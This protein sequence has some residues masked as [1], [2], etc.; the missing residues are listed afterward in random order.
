[1]KD[2]F[3]NKILL[4]AVVLFTTNV[5]G[6]LP[7]LSIAKDHRHFSTANG[8]PFFWMGDTGWLLFVKT[9]REE[10]THYL[11]IRQQQGFNMIQVMVIHDVDHA[12]NKYGDTAISNSDVAQPITTPGNDFRDAKQY[13]FWDHAEF[14][15]QEAAKRNIYLALVPVWGSNIKGG[16]VSEKQAE[17]YAKFLAT[18][19]KKYSNI[20]WL[21]GGDIPGN[22][23]AEVWN[24]I[25]NTLKKYDPQHLVSFHP[26]GRTT[27]SRWFHDQ[28]WLDFNMFQS[29]HRNYAQD[30][31]AGETHY[32]EDNWRYVAEDLALK[33][34]KPTLDGEPSYEGIPQGLHDTTERYWYAADIRRYAYWNVLTGAAG[35]TYGNNAVMQFFQPA[36]HGMSAYGAKEFWTEALFDTAATQMQCVKKLMEL[37]LMTGYR[38]D[39]ALVVNNG[40]RYNYVAAGRGKDF[41]LFYTYNGR[42]FNVRMGK[43]PGAR[44]KANWYNPATGAIKATMTVANYGTRFFD[45]PGY[46]QDGNDWILI[47][48][49]KK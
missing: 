30:T 16:H 17:A 42:N 25:G 13:D 49:T 29:G 6:Q 46:C 33:P 21:N 7:A 18:R 48:E 2:R 39:T 14:I 43:L 19:F 32:G 1:M 22:E 31:S 20:V 15:V 3:L 23:H 37:H 34:A 9:T 44:V 27:S 38:P 26:R 12:V 40:T 28:H 47:L 11:D 10:A 8:K 5:Q 36:D 4:A 24:T 41:E 35:F 45:P